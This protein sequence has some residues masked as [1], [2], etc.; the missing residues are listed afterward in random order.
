M[1]RTDF[2]RAVSLTRLKLRHPGDLAQNNTSVPSSYMA[3]VP[4]S[5]VTLLFLLL[6]LAFRFPSLNAVAAAAATFVMGLNWEF[7]TAIRR[8]DGWARMLAAVPVLWLELL[9]VG[10]GTAVGL[11]SYPFGRR[12]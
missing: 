2:M 10:G 9:V 12:Y 8:S 11:A 3:S 1:L 4:L 6:G 5:G 7:L